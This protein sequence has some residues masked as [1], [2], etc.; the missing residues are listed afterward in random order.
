MN[1]FPG[2]SNKMA[3]LT[4]TTTFAS[5]ISALQN[6]FLRDD[7]DEHERPLLHIR[8]LQTC[9]E[10]GE[11]IYKILTEA[12][13]IGNSLETLVLSI[14]TSEASEGCPEKELGGSM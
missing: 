9:T 12:L 2:T 8:P 10:R 3:Q 4:T 7:D 11:R 6:P 1:R 13:A 5:D 14:T